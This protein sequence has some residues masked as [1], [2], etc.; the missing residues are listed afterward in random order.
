MDDQ[1]VKHKE[2]IPT[3]EAIVFSEGGEIPLKEVVR[4]LGLTQQELSEVVDSYNRSGGGLIL[5][6]DS[7]RVVM[8]VAGNYASA[9][10]SYR[11]N[12]LSEGISKAG[13][14]TLAIVLYKGESTASGVEHIRGVNSGYT[15]RQLTIRGLLN[16]SKVG[17]SYTYIPSVELLSLLGIVKLDDVPGIEEVREQLKEFENKDNNERDD[18]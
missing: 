13:L 1:T 16:K 8:R 4:V 12:T 9:I 17:M 5:V 7:K 6:Q 18:N 3:L 2:I 14:E 15:L 11:K 10:E